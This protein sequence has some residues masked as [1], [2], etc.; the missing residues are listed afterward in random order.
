[1]PQFNLLIQRPSIL[2]FPTVSEIENFKINM[3]NFLHVLKRV[4]NV[5]KAKPAA[6]FFSFTASLLALEDK[7]LN[8]K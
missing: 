1:M 7:M 5:V 4:E 6:R 3:I 8:Y 2:S